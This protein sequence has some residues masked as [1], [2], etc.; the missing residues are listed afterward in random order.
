MLIYPYI[1]T[2]LGV[3]VGIILAVATKKADGTVSGALDRAGF[4][5]NIVLTPVY[6][7]LTPIAV[8]F[9]LLS[10][11]YSSLSAGESV[12]AWIIAVVIASAPLVCGL[13]LGGSVAL[14]KR[15]K[16]KASFIVQFAGGLSIILSVV[17]YV[18]FEGSLLVTIN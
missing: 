8:F 6:V 12:L 14:R 10:E 17:L 15:G 9:G 11:P 16:S 18:V 13:S 1:A 2:L 5:T 7:L 3:A 4:V